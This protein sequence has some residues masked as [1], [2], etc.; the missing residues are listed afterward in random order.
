[1]PT[2]YA[3]TYLIKPFSSF[4][5]YFSTSSPKETFIR[6]PEKFSMTLQDNNVLIKAFCSKRLLIKKAFQKSGHLTTT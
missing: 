1:M 3:S 5:L 2:M 4:V 6:L